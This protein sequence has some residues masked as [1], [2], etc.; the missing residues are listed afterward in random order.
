M[1]QKDYEL[2]EKY[3]NSSEAIELPDMAPTKEDLNQPCPILKE[4]DLKA[5]PVQK[6]VNWNT[7]WLTGLPTLINS[8]ITP[9]GF[10]LVAR[11][12]ESGNIVDMYPIR[13]TVRGLSDIV[14]VDGLAHF[15][16][17]LAENATTL[18]NESYLAE[19]RINELLNEYSKES[20]EKNDSP[21]KI[22]EI[23]HNEDK[24]QAVI[25]W[26]TSQKTSSYPKA[27]LNN[28]NENNG[29]MDTL[30]SLFGNNS[31][32]KTDVEFC[33]NSI[34]EDNT[35]A[36]DP[37]EITDNDTISSEDINIDNSSN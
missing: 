24:T 23:T 28:L 29:V 14:T 25:D 10:G 11:R 1:D 22:E 30:G 33:D 32:I 26:L 13:T 19:S 34:L 4:L 8:I 12:D 18:N 15:S 37:I 17:F 36:V 16:R 27:T 9:F 21:L 31:A 7:F 6:N 3:D 2:L 5:I 20:E 35:V